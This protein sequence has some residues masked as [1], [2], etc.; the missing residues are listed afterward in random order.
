MTNQLTINFL[1]HHYTNFDRDKFFLERFSIILLITN[2][3]KVKLIS[4]VSY[5]QGEE[6][7]FDTIRRREASKIVRAT[8]WSLS[9]HQFLPKKFLNVTV[10]NTVKFCNVKNVSLKSWF[11]MVLKYLRLISVETNYQQSNCSEHR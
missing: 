8:C 1:H 10:L 9:V 4:K 2:R 6:R 5:A 11:L 3:K 7:L